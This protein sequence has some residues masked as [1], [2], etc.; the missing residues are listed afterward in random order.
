MTLVLSPVLQRTLAL[1][2][3]RT[4]H[5]H[6][7]AH[8]LI[9]ASSSA[10]NDVII[11]LVATVR[12]ALVPTLRDLNRKNM[13]FVRFPREIWFRIWGKLPTNDCTKVSH[14]CHDW[15]KTACSWPRLWQEL[16]YSVKYNRESGDL[17]STNRALLKPYV[18]RSMQLPLGLQVNAGGS[19]VG[20]DGRMDNLLCKLKR[21]SLRTRHV[22]VLLASRRATQLDDRAG[23]WIDNYPLVGML[24]FP[25]LEELDLQG[26]AVNL[27]HS[28][29]KSD[30]SAPSLRLLRASV[31]DY[32]GFHSL[33]AS[34]N[35]L[36]DL[37]IQFGG[38]VT[39][40]GEEYDNLRLILPRTLNRVY[41]QNFQV[42]F[43]M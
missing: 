26:F 15:R 27:K 2:V 28:H 19:G 11:A 36:Q 30:F 14:V 4:F 25:S 39:L 24:K 40:T 5:E 35:K 17:T 16:A 29:F 31:L 34:L 32:R 3:M 41:F 6:L 21:R 20:V 33:I 38:N 13:L 22:S 9:R 10:L 23:H 43:G 37:T 1:N 12:T 8:S 42:S 18:N 7:N